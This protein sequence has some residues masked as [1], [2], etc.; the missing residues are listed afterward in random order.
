MKLIGEKNMKLKEDYSSNKAKLMAVGGVIHGQKRVS[1]MEMNQN[2]QQWF[3]SQQK[4][5]I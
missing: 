1:S 5:Y 2:T 4:Q 3:M